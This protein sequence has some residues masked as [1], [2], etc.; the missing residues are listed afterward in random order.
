MKIDKNITIDIIDEK[1]ATE[2]D[3]VNISNNNLFLKF[4]KPNVF[5]L[6]PE[7]S[8]PPGIVM[9]AAKTTVAISVAPSIHAVAVSFIHLSP[10]L[11]KF[12]CCSV[13]ISCA[14]S[15]L[16]FLVSMYE[17]GTISLTACNV[18]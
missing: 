18:I 6:S 7:S 8:F 14:S 1:R 13:N 4:G 16:V 15:P 9:A 5:A 17:R 11:R 12:S 3:K 2:S 10:S